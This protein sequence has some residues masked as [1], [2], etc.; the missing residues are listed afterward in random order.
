MIYG[1]YIINKAGGLIYQKVRVLSLSL[2]SCPSLNWCLFALV[3][4]RIEI[5]G[6][7]I[8]SHSDPLYCVLSRHYLRFCPCSPRIIVCASSSRCG[9]LVLRP[10]SSYPRFFCSCQRRCSRCLLFVLDVVP[11]FILTIIF[12]SSQSSQSSLPVVTFPIPSSF[13]APAFS[14]SL[15]HH[16]HGHR[17][18]S[19]HTIPS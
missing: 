2:R 11:V 6:V 10:S 17:R 4:G 8:S 7:H 16:R 5:S 13:S 15:G 3:K 9:C 1:V 14:R 18:I 12:S 19:F